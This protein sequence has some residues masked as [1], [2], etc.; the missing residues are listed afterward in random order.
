MES[1]KWTE[2]TDTWSALES[3]VFEVSPGID[4]YNILYGS[5]DD[6]KI[7]NGNNYL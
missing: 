3:T 7:S 5:D 1:G 4:F 6:D 2:A